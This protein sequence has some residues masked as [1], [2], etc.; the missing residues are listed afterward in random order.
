MRKKIPCG[1]Q[2]PDDKVLYPAFYKLS[3]VTHE[4][5]MDVFILNLSIEIN[6]K[7]ESL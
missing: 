5:V 4:V 2:V 3:L 6:I 1:I 7:L